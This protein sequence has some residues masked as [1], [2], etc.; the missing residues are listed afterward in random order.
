MPQPNA[1]GYVPA[2]TDVLSQLG[3]A[4]EGRTMAL[5]TSHSSLRAVAQRLRPLLEPHGIPVLAQ[6]VDGSA[7]YIMSAFADEPRS[8]LLGTASFWEGVDMP[9]G[10]LKALVITR[11]PF[12]VPTDPIVQSRSALYDDPFAEYSVPNA[13]LRFRQGIGRLIRNKEDRG[14]IVILDSRIISH[15]Y[16]RTFQDSMPPCRQTPC[17]TGNVGMLAA[18]WL[19]S[20]PENSRRGGRRGARS[21]SI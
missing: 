15:G 17:L 4:L 19:E 11:L 20:R 18:R 1:N 5:F 14:N 13:V 7:P 3:R 16:G 9:S 2:V 10:L 21:R 8:V 12:Q 6:G